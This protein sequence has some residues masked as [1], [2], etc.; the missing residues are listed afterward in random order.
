MTTSGKVLVVGEAPGPSGSGGAAEGRIGRRL[1]ALS[2]LR[3]EDYLER[4]ERVNILLRWPGAAG[5]GSRFPA[6]KARRAAGKV[7][8][9]A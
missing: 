9:Q 1:A 6:A 4:T 7:L 8:R 5:N 3:Y 2:C